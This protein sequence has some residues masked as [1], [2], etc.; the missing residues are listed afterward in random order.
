V[1]RFLPT[2]GRPFASL[3][4]GRASVG[5]P[6]A[7]AEPDEV[8]GGGDD[9]GTWVANPGGVGVRGGGGV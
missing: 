4:P 6:V 8:S 3:T 5:I 2:P 7:A 1:S 9:V